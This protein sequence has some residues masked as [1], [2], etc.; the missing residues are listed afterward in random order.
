MTEI[1]ANIDTA[2]YLCLAKFTMILAGPETADRLLDQWEEH[3]GGGDGGDRAFG[4]P[5]PTIMI[6]REQR[7][8]PDMRGMR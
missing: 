8:R 3:Y 5:L 7:D 6:N 2:W 4:R 1:E